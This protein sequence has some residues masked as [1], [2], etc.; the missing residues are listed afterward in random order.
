MP[1]IDHD[2]LNSMTSLNKA[3]KVA[4]F[5]RVPEPLRRSI[6]PLTEAEYLQVLEVANAFPNIEILAAYFK[7]QGDKLVTPN[8]IVQFVLKVRQ[9]GGPELSSADLEERD[10]DEAEDG[11]S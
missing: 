3:S 9:V 8:A 1:H 7:V 2:M 10:D 6:L 4:D 11:T 5:L